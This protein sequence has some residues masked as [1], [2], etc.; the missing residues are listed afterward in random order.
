[1]FDLEDIRMI[2]DV[3]KQTQ[4]YFYSNEDF[5]IVK[6][7]VDDILSLINNYNP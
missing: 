3:D 4:V 6:E 2:L 1:M 7:S 5:I